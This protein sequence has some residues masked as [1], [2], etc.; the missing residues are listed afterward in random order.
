MAAPY[1]V[2]TLPP[3]YPAIRHMPRL[4]LGAMDV[5]PDSDVPPYLQV[6]AQ[7]RDAI[8]AGTYPPRTRL[9]SIAQIRRETGI[10]RNTA[11][12]TINVLAREGYVRVVEGWGSF[13]TEE[14]EWPA[15]GTAAPDDSSS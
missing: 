6:A 2:A 11:R 14:T 4:A 1:P 7:L 8:R 9:P 15:A 10:A 3:V 13:V 12:K 5:D